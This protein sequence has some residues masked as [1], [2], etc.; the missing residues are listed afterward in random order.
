MGLV[1]LVEDNGIQAV[2]SYGMSG[3]YL[4]AREAAA[5]GDKA[6]AVNA[7]RR[8]L[9]YWTNPPLGFLSLWENDSYWGAVATSLKS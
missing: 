8:T 1:R 3:W 5:S 2:D 7:L 9:S 4:V 6:T